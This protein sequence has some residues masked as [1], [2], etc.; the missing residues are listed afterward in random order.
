MVTASRGLVWKLQAEA[1]K[2]CWAVSLGMRRAKY[3]LS[4]K[5]DK[6]GLVT[7]GEAALLVTAQHMQAHCGLGW[8]E[9]K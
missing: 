5:F 9:S 2:V 3:N 4:R 7:R 6:V 8:M 1:G